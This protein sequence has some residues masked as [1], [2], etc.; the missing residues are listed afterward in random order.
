MLTS[1]NLNT[2]FPE[3]LMYR[4]KP[5]YLGLSVMRCG[6]I[7]FHSRYY[8]HGFI[9]FNSHEQP[10]RSGLLFTHYFFPELYARYCATSSMLTQV[11]KY[12]PCTHGRNIQ[13]TANKQLHK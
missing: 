9:S 2:V 10:M 12:V 13:V 7:Q 8:V 1:G 5:I 6:I 4:K 3:N 11:T